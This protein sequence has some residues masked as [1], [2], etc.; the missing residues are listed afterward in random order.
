[1]KRILTVIVFTALTGICLGQT[2]DL[3]ATTQ[4]LT[5]Q[6]FDTTGT[7]AL[8]VNNDTLHYLD[9][10]GATSPP[11]SHLGSAKVVYRYP[12]PWHPG[13]TQTYFGDNPASSPTGA[14]VTVTLSV[15]AVVYE[16]N[17]P[18]YQGYVVGILETFEFKSGTE[19]GELVIFEPGSFAPEKAQSKDLLERLVS[20]KPPRRP[21]VPGE[22]RPAWSSAKA[23]TTPIRRT[24]WVGTK[25]T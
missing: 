17:G 19:S 20:G 13:E 21:L 3:R 8:V 25:P 16:L 4:H 9:Y 7:A 23:T 5:G 2:W 14:A 22:S 15:D 10:N 1:M 12:A 18:N 11:A 6:A 24:P